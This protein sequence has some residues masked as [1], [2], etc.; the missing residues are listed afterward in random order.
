ML[1][2]MWLRVAL[3]L[4]VLAS[5]LLLINF[6]QRRGADQER[7]KTERQNTDARNKADDRGGAYDRCDGM[8]DFRTGKCARGF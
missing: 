4:A 5:V 6:L 8:F 2:S 7:V 3:V 1:T